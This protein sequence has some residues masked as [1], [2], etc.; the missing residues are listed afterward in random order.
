MGKIKPV[1]TP[2]LNKLASQF[3][4]DFSLFLWYLAIIKPIK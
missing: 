2:I 3:F 1:N 4:L